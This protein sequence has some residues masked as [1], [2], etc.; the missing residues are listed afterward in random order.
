MNPNANA[1]PQASTQRA[2]TRKAKK[3]TAAPIEIL[4]NRKIA[5]V[6][7]ADTK[8]VVLKLRPGEVIAGNPS[9]RLNS[10]ILL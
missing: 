1:D 2:M 7:T 3:T 10:M 5:F 9:A 4:I 6:S 8:R